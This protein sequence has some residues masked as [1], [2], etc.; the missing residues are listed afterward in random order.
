MVVEHRKKVALYMPK[1]QAIYFEGIEDTNGKLLPLAFPY[2]EDRDLVL[3]AL[4]VVSTE[5]KY[6]LLKINL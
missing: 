1:S 4:I 6:F 2:V 5:N 3:G